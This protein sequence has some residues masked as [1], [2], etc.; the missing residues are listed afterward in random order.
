MFFFYKSRHF[1][2]PARHFSICSLVSV[3]LNSYVPQQS[4]QCSPCCRVIRYIALSS[5]WGIIRPSEVNAGCG[6]ALA[7][8]TLECH[9]SPVCRAYSGILDHPS[10]M[11]TLQGI[12]KA[13]QISDQD[14]CLQTYWF[15]EV[16]NMMCMHGGMLHVLTQIQRKEMIM[17]SHSHATVME[18]NI[19]AVILWI[20]GSAQYIASIG[21]IWH[22]RPWLSRWRWSS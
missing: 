15:L 10:H 3:W 19:H 13:S 18:V 21:V 12:Y 1:N 8:S 2:I 4:Q 7:E 11:D 6:A 14:I 16:M 22:V 9:C 17:F 5:S 20:L